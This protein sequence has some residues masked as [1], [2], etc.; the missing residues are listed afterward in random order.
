MSGDLN[1]CGC[2]HPVIDH[3]VSVRSG[4]AASEPLRCSY[5][6]CGK[7]NPGAAEFARIWATE[8]AAMEKKLD[9]QDAQMA[10]GL[11]RSDGGPMVGLAGF[12]STG[13]IGGYRCV[14]CDTISPDGSEHTP[15]CGQ[16]ARDRDAGQQRWNDQLASFIPVTPARQ[17]FGVECIPGHPPRFFRPADT[18]KPTS[19]DLA[20]AGVHRKK[21]EEMETT[22]ESLRSNLF[23]AR[24]ALITEGLARQAA[25]AEVVRLRN[26]NG[27]LWAMLA[28]HQAIG[29]DMIRH[30]AECDREMKA[31]G[32]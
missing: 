6:D 22:E 30:L 12:V 2:G 14:E 1:L 15:E 16:P 3:H 25:D 21:W 13:Q 27:W 19:D 7:A 5:C 9:A 24:D 31:S 32:R 4:T 8:K 26:E 28:R 10:T 20:P 29:A 18:E 17:P 23:A 11:F